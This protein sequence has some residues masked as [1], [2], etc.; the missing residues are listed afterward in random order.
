MII[1]PELWGLL[2]SLFDAVSRDCFRPVIFN[3]ADVVHMDLHRP[4]N[5]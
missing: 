5:Q 4:A 1:N 2:G 3:T